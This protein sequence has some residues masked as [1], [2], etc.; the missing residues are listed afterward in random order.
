ML[1]N[2]KINNFTLV[3]QAGSGAYGL[4]FQAIDNN[5]N[6]QQVAIK[7]VL[8]QP[9]PAHLPEEEKSCIIKTQLL[10]YFQ[11]NNNE[12]V[13]PTI[14]LA[15]IRNLTPKQL[16]KIPHYKEI[17]LHLKVH[18]HKNIVSIHQVLEG[19]IATFIVMDYYPIDLFTSIVDLEHFVQDGILIKKVFLQLCSAID[20]CHEM[21]V[22]HCDIK[23]ENLLLDD[24][25]NVYL[26]DFGLSTTSPFLTPNV[27]IGSSY[28][29][30]PERISYDENRVDNDD[31]EL[32]NCNGDIWSLGIILINLTCIRNPWLKAHHDEDNTFHY[33]LKD[34][35]VLK[36]ILPISDSLFYILTKILQVNPHNRIDI[37]SLMNEI[38]NIEQFTTSGPLNYVPRLSKELFAKY[39]A[40]DE[41]INTD[42]D[43]YIYK[44]Y[45]TNENQFNE[46][47]NYNEDEYS[48]NTNS[49]I[50]SSME[51]TPYDS[52]ANDNFNDNTNNNN[53]KNLMKKM[54]HLKMKENLSNV[55][56]DLSATN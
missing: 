8:K 4:V 42:Y 46:N 10:Q 39:V 17:Q 51:T 7:A 16:T 15:T 5:N 18:S 49:L 9:L 22:Y 33:F 14:E 37:K 13:L 19:T 6:N 50:T 53:N 31:D 23:P 1:C 26:C 44:S 2:C 52:D 11:N 47:D 45:T 28:Y 38:V 24:D 3:L 36:K 43:D 56:M 25:D 32:P 48:C 54:V 29:M 35:N 55:K 20:Y 41:T 30:A 34:T 27:S 40:I 12:L 21:D